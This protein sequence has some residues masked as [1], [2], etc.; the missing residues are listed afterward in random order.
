MKEESKSKTAPSG[1]VLV[2]LS[3]DPKIHQDV[4]DYWNLFSKPMKIEVFLAAM[5]MYRQEGLAKEQ[6]AAKIAASGGIGN[7]FDIK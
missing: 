4:I 7:I 6:G 1:R 5:R 2:R 3:L